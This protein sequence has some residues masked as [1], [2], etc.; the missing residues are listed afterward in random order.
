MMIG[1]DIIKNDRINIEDTS[2]IEKI[3]T[4]KELR[5]YDKLKQSER[6]LFVAGRFAAKEAIIKALEDDINM[7]EISILK[8][9]NGSPNVIIEKPFVI[10]LSIAHEKEYTIA[11]AIS[12]PL[13]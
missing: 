10:K 12:L 11:F 8:N 13:N 2:F 9:K 1:C 3:L 6:K 4:I 7:Q 5:L